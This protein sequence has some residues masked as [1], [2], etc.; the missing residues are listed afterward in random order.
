VSNVNATLARPKASEIT[1][2]LAP[3]NNIRLAKV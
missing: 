1:F 3:R 2:G